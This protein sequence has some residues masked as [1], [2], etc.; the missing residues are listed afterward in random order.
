MPNM[1]SESEPPPPPSLTHGRSYDPYLHNPPLLQH[2]PSKV[3]GGRYRHQT[4]TPDGPDEAETHLQTVLYQVQ[5]LLK[6]DLGL[7]EKLIPLQKEGPSPQKVNIFLSPDY[8]ERS[9]LLI[10]M[11]NLY[12]GIWSRS[13]ISKGVNDSGSM[14][15]YLKRARREGY[16]VIVLN[17]AGAADAARLFGVQF[18]G[19]TAGDAH[20]E[21]VWDTLIKDLSSDLYVLGYARGGQY[22]KHLVKYDGGQGVLEQRLKAIALIESSHMITKQDSEFVQ[23]IFSAKAT[24]WMNNDQE[25]G[26]LI[27]DK[28]R[29]GCACL[30]SGP[31]RA[32]KDSRNS[33]LIMNQVGSA[34]CSQSVPSC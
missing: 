30:S 22:I 2:G 32:F 13:L 34:H 18:K 4:M 33:A 27:P 31:V 12:P 17:P 3:L 11:S 20:I 19:T 28:Y 15:P 24:A 25:A 16:G 6:T 1:S 8:S 9:R 23:S 26:S 14:I 10:V 21:I 7:V 29:L 5:S